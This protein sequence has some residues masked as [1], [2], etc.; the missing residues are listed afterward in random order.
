MNMSEQVIKHGLKHV[1]AASHKGTCVMLNDQGQ[2]VHITKDMIVSACQQ[3]LNQ[4]R[5]I[6][7]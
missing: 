5:S 2:E 1:L 4:C 7:V 3:L 6:K